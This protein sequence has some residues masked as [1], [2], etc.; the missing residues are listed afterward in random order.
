MGGMLLLLVS[1]VPYVNMFFGYLVWGAIYIMNAVVS[2]VEGLP[3]SIIKGLYVS[4]FEFALLLTAFVLL[5]LCVAMRRRRLF[6]AMLS[7]MLVFM[8]SVTLRL[9]RDKDYQAMTFYSLRQHTAVDFIKDGQHVLL[10][11]SALTQDPS[12]VD[13]S[14]RGNWTKRHLSQKPEVM[15]L[16]A[17][18]EGTFVRKKSNL[19][20]FDGKL[21]ALWDGET[22]AS[23]MLSY[24]IPVDYLLVRGRQRPDLQ[25][26][27][28]S[29]D[30]GMLLIDATVPH[31]LVEKW[32][33]QA[34]SFDLPYYSVAE[35]AYEA[36][37]AA[38]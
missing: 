16:D 11:D 9:Y 20:S 23:R 5:L 19:V 12:T 34:R 24:R 1:W 30:V 32:E 10:A 14:L 27:I 3:F 35:G 31:Y 25:S 37:L 33:T 21:L 15:G 4:R 8:V 18:F 7:V 26:V 29:Y 22:K 38:R 17:D 36:D 2:W 13:Y 28:N 6:V